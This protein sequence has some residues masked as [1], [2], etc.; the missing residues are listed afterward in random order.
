M[1]YKKRLIEPKVSEGLVLGGGAKACALSVDNSTNLELTKSQVDGHTCEGLFLIK[2]L[3]VRG[4]TLN[5]DLLGWEKSILNL[6]HTCSYTCMHTH[7]YIS[8]FSYTC[9]RTHIMYMCAHTHT[10]V[11]SITSVPLENPN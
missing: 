7:E 2:L 8:T 10:H 5:P 11:H 3:E 1:T 6:G 9:T 4:S